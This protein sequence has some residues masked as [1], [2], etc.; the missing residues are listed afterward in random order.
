MSKVF[1]AAAVVLALQA[2]APAGVE[3]TVS[4]CRVALDRCLAQCNKYP[5][6]VREGCM[7]GC[8]IGY[9]NCEPSAPAK[10]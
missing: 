3:A 7:L 5:W 8:G 10:G 6:P 2:F 1:R 4:P 9:L